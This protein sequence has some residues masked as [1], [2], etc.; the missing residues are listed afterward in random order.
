MNDVP[1]LDLPTL[2]SRVY[3]RYPSFLVDA[4]VEHVPGTRLVAVKNVTV[5]EEFFQGHFPGSPL[6]PG[7]LMI[8][9][10]T[11]GLS[12]LGR[13]GTPVQWGAAVFVQVFEPAALGGAEAFTRELGWLR[14]SCE[15]IPPMQG[16]EKV[17]LP[18]D[19][20]LARRRK[21]LAD[22]IDLYPGIMQRLRREAEALGVPVP[23]ALAG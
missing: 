18:G 3:Y 10:L 15:A 22:G 19:A 17:R 2:L 20:A 7:V 6:M 8:E 16:F 4:V 23:A 13:S 1:S 21:A 11:Q 9:A 5:N 14:R 12:G